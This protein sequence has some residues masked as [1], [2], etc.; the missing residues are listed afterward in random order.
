MPENADPN[1]CTHIIY[2]FAKVVDDQLIPYE[3]NDEN[4]EWSKG[5]YQRTMDLKLINPKLK[6][7]I[8]VGGWNHG[9]GPF[10]IMVHNVT[11]RRNFVKNSLEFLKKHKFDGLGK[12]YWLFKMRIKI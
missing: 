4:S 8:G 5:L 9:P 7:L 1:L 2:A 11:M 12:K 6:V 3:W 10:S